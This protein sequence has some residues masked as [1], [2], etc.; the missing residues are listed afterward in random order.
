MPNASSPNTTTMR[1]MIA[2]SRRMRRRS[3]KFT[4]GLKIY[5]KTNASMN[6]VSTSLKKYN[7]QP[8]SIR[9]RIRPILKHV[10]DGLHSYNSLC[11]RP[12]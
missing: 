9:K 7:S 3:R 6:G 11:I 1:M 10:L 5:A 2:S 12:T 4:T 8:N